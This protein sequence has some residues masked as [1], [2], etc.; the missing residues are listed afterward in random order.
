MS[1]P[2]A[3]TKYNKFHLLS[4]IFLWNVDLAKDRH[5]ETFIEILTLRLEVS[6]PFNSPIEKQ[7][8]RR[9]K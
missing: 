8:F 9:R 3:L 2:R 1:S 7:A 5:D 4:F 6:L